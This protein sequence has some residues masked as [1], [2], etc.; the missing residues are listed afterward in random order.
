[1]TATAQPL[2]DDELEAAVRA[3]Y[4]AVLTRDPQA[5]RAA[6]DGL[7]PFA[8]ED[9]LPLLQR[10]LTA[11]LWTTHRRARPDERRLAALAERTAATH[12]GWAALPD[13]GTLTAVLRWAAG[14]TAEPGVDDPAALLLALVVAGAGLLGALPDGQLWT[15][16]LDLA[17]DALESAADG[18]PGR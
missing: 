7:L 17:E 16:V 10:L 11:L 2:I 13:A 8:A 9:Y 4:A 18:R 5:A 1:M 14:Y 12:A 3:A 6:F 15:D